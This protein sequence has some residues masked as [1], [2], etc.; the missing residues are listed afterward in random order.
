MGLSLKYLSPSSIG[1]FEQ[2][3]ENFYIRYASEREREPQ[4]NAMA[5]G[6]AF[7]ALVKGA[8]GGLGKE[9]VVELYKSQVE[10]QWQTS[11]TVW[12]KECFEMYVACGAYADLEKDIELFGSGV[13]SVPEY[14]KIIEDTVQSGQA[15]APASGIALNIEADIT[16][17]VE[18]EGMVVPFRGKPDIVFSGPRGHGILDWKV[19]G[20][21]SSASPKPGY[22]RLR[23]GKHR[24][25]CHK[26]VCP[27]SWRGREGCTIGGRL[28]DMD[29]SW[30]RQLAIYGWLSGFEVGEDFLV[31]IDQ[32]VWRNG[33]GRTAEF[34]GIVGEA[35][36]K[37]LFKRATEIWEI[38][39]SDHVF[40]DMSKEE[41]QGRE[42]T[43]SLSCGNELDWLQ[44]KPKPWYG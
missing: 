26:S 8:L 23:G 42:A 6:S 20:Y 19:N 30:A 16:G 3:V 41:S 39:N 24:G 38:V 2:D 34:R 22:L 10:E 35:W 15:G 14:D 40:R 33:K 5:V 7:D 31:C 9:E 12:G 25:E 1:L 44:V 36:Q 43:L 28:E 32:L 11:A 13:N 17:D 18:F 37:E 4:T 29:M 21:F 27:M